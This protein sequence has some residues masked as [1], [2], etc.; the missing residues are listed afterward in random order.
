MERGSMVSSNVRRHQNAFLEGMYR[1]T[2]DQR[3]ASENA[4]GTID[5]FVIDNMS[6]PVPMETYAYKEDDFDIEDPEEELWNLVLSAESNNNYNAYWSNANNSEI[7]FT[8][9][10]LNEVEAWQR[11]FVRVKG[12][13]S[14]AVGRYQI[15]PKTMKYLRR[16]LNLSGEEKFDEAL[17]DRMGRALLDRRGYSKFLKGSLSKEEF[18]LN[19]SKEWA[20]IPVLSDTQGRFTQLKSGQ[21]YYFNPERP[22]LNSAHISVSDFNSVL[23]AFEVASAD[24]DQK[25][26]V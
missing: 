25:E 23:D 5:Q 21:S 1:K 3:L 8:E 11:D 4:H 24:N 10:T 15:V 19:L 17:Q 14:S 26:N 7:R 22:N 16:V 6:T 9:M 2:V 20:A 12:N 13:P 18:A